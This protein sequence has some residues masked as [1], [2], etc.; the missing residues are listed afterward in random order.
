LFAGSALT[1]AALCSARPQLTGGPSAWNGDDVASG[2]TWLIAMVC[3]TWLAV[4]TLACLCALARGEHAT[5]LRIAAF[6]PPLARRV[7]QTTLV[8]TAVL[9]P[10]AAYATSPPTP[11]VLH[12]GAGGRLTTLSESAA[13]VEIPVVRAPPPSTPS[14]PVASTAV[15]TEPTTAPAPRAPA[16]VAP[17]LTAPIP[18]TTPARTAPDRTYVVRAGDNLWR[19]AGAHV[20]RASGTA[21]SDE[22]IA[23][24]WQRVIAAN[25]TTLRSG[26]PSLIFPGEVIAL[27]LD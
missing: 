22:T 11:L 2:A 1:T 27:P 5:A 8:T 23:R 19:I 24:Y 17:T 18:R 20:A 3:A 25:R 9:L 26:N 12:V 10:T 16:P 15:P 7:L 13:P 14:T 21:P 4:T 6:A